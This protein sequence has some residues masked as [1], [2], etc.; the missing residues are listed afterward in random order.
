[1]GGRYFA[2]V[3]EEGNWSLELMLRSGWNSTT[4]TATDDYG[5]TSV[6][7]VRVAPTTAG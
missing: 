4:F 3:D 1:M 7:Q 6:R 2:E 5:L